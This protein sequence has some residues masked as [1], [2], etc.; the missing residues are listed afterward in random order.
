[1]DGI[2]RVDKPVGVKKTHRNLSPPNRDCERNDVNYYRIVET[3][4][5]AYILAD[6]KK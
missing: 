4:M 3:A 2:G 6:E 1:V 5:T